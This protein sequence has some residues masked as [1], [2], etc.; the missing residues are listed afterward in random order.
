MTWQ[1]YKQ[2]LKNTLIVEIFFKKMVSLG[3]NEII[4][5]HFIDFT[6]GLRY[7]II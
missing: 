4:L 3:Q 5:T 2:N 1:I 6:L 7:I